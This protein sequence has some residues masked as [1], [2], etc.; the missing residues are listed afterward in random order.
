V[1]FAR[2][3]VYDRTSAIADVRRSGAVRLQRAALPTFAMRCTHVGVRGRRTSLDD[4]SETSAEQP[5]KRQIT[6]HSG[7]RLKQ[8]P[9]AESKDIA[10]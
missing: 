5:D 7:H 9:V 6:V 8:M 2:S 4:P 3:L 1:R 10:P